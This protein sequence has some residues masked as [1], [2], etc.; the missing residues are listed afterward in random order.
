MIQ[1]AQD[2]WHTPPEPIASMLDTP[3]LPVVAF[4]PKADWIVELGRMT[5]PPISELAEPTVA[6]AGLQ[7][8]PET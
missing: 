3:S 6:L 5:L 8:N 2:T 4:S 7:I 1:P